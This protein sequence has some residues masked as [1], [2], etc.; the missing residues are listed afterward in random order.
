MAHPSNVPARVLLRGVLVAIVALLLVA[1]IPANAQAADLAP[2]WRHEM[3]MRVNAIRA[4][5]GAPALRPCGALRRSAQQY[6]M[7]MASTD[8]Y[9]HVGQDGSEPWNRMTRQGYTWR[10]AAENIAG[11][12]RS[13]AEVVEDWVAS[14]DHYAN[15]I[16]PA[17]RHVG[18]GYSADPASTYGSYWVQNFGSGHGC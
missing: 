16:N 9:G 4:E 10:V 2:G 5:A 6:A 17:L 18:F 14:P 7:V 13:V 15:L 8:A 3:L 1:L 12:Q 11:G